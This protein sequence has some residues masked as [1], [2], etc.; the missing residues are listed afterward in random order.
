MF[1]YSRLPRLVGIASG[2]LLVAH[3][4]YSQSHHSVADQI[5][6]RPPTLPVA[7]NNNFDP[8]G[9][10]APDSTV[11][12]GSR[13]NTACPE[14]VGTLRSHM[15]ER[16]YGL[17]T[18]DQ[19]GIYVQLSDTTAQQVVLA[20]RNEANTYYERAFLPLPDTNSQEET[21]VRFA[22]PDQARPLEI[23]ENYHWTLVL[24]CG[25]TV[26]PDD[27]ILT[28]WVQR[29]AALPEGSAKD[30][31]VEWLAQNGYWYDLL[32]ALY[33]VSRHETVVPIGTLLP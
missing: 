31:A 7:F 28:G 18:Q 19:P 23:G 16:N 14:N 33:R 15:P 26:Q 5:A 22:L 25:E 13:T 9:D 20:F 2:L 12:A 4:A 24:V 27:P 1:S 32:D 11:G 10:D 8:P 17:T 21:L 29:T 3:P 30:G 6:Q